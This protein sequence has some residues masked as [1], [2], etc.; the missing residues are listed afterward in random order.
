MIVLPADHLIKDRA[1]FQAT[2]RT[3]VAAARE[4]GELV[5]IGIKPTWACPGFGYIEQGARVQLK[6]NPG[7]QAVYEVARF[8]EKPNAELAERF[9]KQGNFRWNAGMFIWPLC[10]ILGALQRH[11]APLASF[12]EALHG[13]GDFATTL[14]E[15]F[16]ELPKISIDYAIMEKAK[17]VL[18]VEAAFDWDDVG[19][20]TAIAKYLRH[21][22]D[23]NAAN[24]ERLTTQDAAGNIVYTT[25]P[26]MVG[27]QERGGEDQATGGEGAAGVAV[28][29]TLRTDDP[30]PGAGMMIGRRAAERAGHRFL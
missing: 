5:T 20:W 21:D 2:L 18:V 4:T 9:L 27:H 15:R 6:D 8:R 7:G 23:E 28:M 12:V 16:P 10:A 19:S 24:T 11:A 14:A 26:G 3:A 17:R 1:A 22:T 29:E 13:G 25:R 30:A